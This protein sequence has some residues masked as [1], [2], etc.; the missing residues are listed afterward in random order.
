MRFHPQLSQ[1]LAILDRVTW[2]FKLLSNCIMIVPLC[3]CLLPCNK[4]SLWSYYLL[5]HEFLSST[6]L[7]SISFCPRNLNFDCR[8]YSPPKIKGSWYLPLFLR[9]WQTPVMRNEEC[10]V[11]YYLQKNPRTRHTTP[12]G[13]YGLQS[14][15]RSLAGQSF[16]CS[17]GRENETS[18]ET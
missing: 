16:H 7:S 12:W 1:P 2:H 6:N 10:Y 17:H 3:F 8:H 18:T 5:L 11:R 13:S 4:Q 14:V 15:N 9:S